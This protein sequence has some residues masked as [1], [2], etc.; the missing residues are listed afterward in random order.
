MT[1][2]SLSPYDNH[3]AAHYGFTV[4][5]ITLLIIW[6]GAIVLWIYRRIFRGNTSG[7]QLQ[8]PPEKDLESAAPLTDKTD[9]LGRNK[10][11]DNMTETNQETSTDIIS[12]EHVQGE[13]GHLKRP[14][15]KTRD[16]K[17]L[18]GEAAPAKSFTTQ[19]APPTFDQFLLYV[20]ALG[21]IMFFFYLCD[22]RKV[23]II[24]SIQFY[25]IRIYITYFV[26]HSV[27]S[28]C[29]CM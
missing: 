7:G 9:E 25:E 5:Q 19:A 20:M 3:Q 11:G 24:I 15:E 12:N 8:K 14:N 29:E 10:P 6:I 28:N 27:L 2:F 1:F 17:S 22:Y 4:P 16:T 23:T 26:V 21:V 18:T 13:N